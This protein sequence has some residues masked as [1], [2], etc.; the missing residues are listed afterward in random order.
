M[1]LKYMDIVGSYDFKQRIVDKV[2]T[3]FEEICQT[4]EIIESKK[5]ILRCKI[6]NVYTKFVKKWR[7]AN[8]Q[9]EKFDR[10][11]KVWLNTS[12]GIDE[13]IQKD[14]IEDSASSSKR[15][16]PEKEFSEL[17]D[18]SKRR[19]IANEVDRKSDSSE[20]VLM[21]ARRT[22]FNNQQFNLMNVLGH[23]LKNQNNAH[24]M[25]VKLKK[26]RG[27]MSAEEAFT[28]FIDNGFSKSQYENIHSADPARFPSYWSIRKMKAIC[29]PPVNAIEITAKKI[30]VIFNRFTEVRLLDKI[31]FCIFLHTFNK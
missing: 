13:F 15:G 7:S 18:R 1:A 16:R 8:R 19:L 21:I 24:S 26:H 10:V 12:F 28:F 29:A 22:A 14:G 4:Y 31:C 2:T 23:I 20:K 30:K 25:F 6:R 11:N 27:L 5:E 17:S 9:K 3:T